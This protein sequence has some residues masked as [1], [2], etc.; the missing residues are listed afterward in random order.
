MQDASGGGARIA[1][2]VPFGSPAYDAGLE[3]DD[4]IMSI[5]G[6]G[7]SGLSDVERAI[8]S[9]RPGDVVPLTF[10]RRGQRV[11]GTLRLVAD[12]RQELAPI[13]DTG[14]PLTAAERQFREAWLGSA[15]PRVNRG[16]SQ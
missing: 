4:V 6:V 11:S 14:Q 5:G 2:S 13:E 3:R 16:A 15:A 8:R 1:S 9:R 10:D 12:P 7:V